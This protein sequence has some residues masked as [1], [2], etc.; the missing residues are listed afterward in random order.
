MLRE[1]VFVAF[2][3]ALMTP[4]AV[5]DIILDYSPTEVQLGVA[6]D[7][8]LSLTANPNASDNCPDQV[9]DRSVPA[10]GEHSERVEVGLLQVHGDALWLLDDA[11]PPRPWAS[12][13]SPRLRSSRRHTVSIPQSK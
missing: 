2:G 1:L 8:T 7:I 4:L 3:A 13:P 9:G 10:L 11:L 5:A 12:P 6:T